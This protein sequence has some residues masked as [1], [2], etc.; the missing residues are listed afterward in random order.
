MNAIGK[1]IRIWW[2]ECPL[3]FAFVRIVLLAC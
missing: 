3:K 2:R 1:G